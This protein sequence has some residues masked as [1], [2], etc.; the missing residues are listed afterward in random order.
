MLQYIILGSLQDAIDKLN[1]IVS[2]SLL[3][4][5]LLRRCL[6]ELPSTL[7]SSS[8]VQK[9]NFTIHVCV[10]HQELGSSLHCAARCEQHT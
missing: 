3:C 2:T 6:L 8:C 4:P 1:G 9:T 5:E 7:S 10:E